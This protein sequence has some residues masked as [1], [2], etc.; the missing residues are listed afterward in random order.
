M[1]IVVAIDA[2]VLPITSVRRVVVMVVILVMDGKK[3]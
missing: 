2:K 1:L 3:V